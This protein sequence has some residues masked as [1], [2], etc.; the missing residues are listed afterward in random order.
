MSQTE[1]KSRTGIIV[2]LIIVVIIVGGIVWFFN[3]AS[4]ERMIKNFQYNNLGGL[5]RTVK[6]YGN[7]GDLIK[8]YE[9]KLDIKDTELGNKVLFDLNGK[10][11]TIY[12]ATVITEEK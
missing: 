7:N 9:G 4:G 5:E 12:N 10:R 6:V 8:E 2:T 3:T 11:I 1:K